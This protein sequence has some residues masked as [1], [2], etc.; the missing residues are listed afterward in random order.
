MQFIVEQDSFLLEYLYTKMN[1]KD[2]KNYLSKGSVY[3]NGNKQT[4]FKYEL[5]KGDIITFNKTN[6]SL[7]ILYEDEEIIVINKPA[8]L[9]TIATDK[10]K[11]K[12]AYHLVKEYLQKKNQKVFIVHRLDQETSGVVMF[13]KNE[14]IK[15][16]L[17]NNWNDIVEIRGYMAVIEGRLNNPIGTLK[18]YLKESKTKS[19]YVSDHDGKLAITHYRTIASNKR[20][21]LLEINLDTGRKNQIRVQFANIK[22]PLVGDKKYG[23]M[24]NPIK[25]MALHSHCLKLKHP[26]THKELLFEARIPSV[27]EQL[28]KK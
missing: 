13:A 18:N 15:N 25:R 27:M 1:K 6:N 17:Q 28:V 11:E 23:S 3:V 10:E 22:H 8:G 16:Q 12:T 21:S 24:I 14:K 4:H 19:V 20:Y 9:L 7:E 26:I 5:H 2:A